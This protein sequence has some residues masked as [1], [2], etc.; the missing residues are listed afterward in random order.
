MNFFFEK[1]A[2]IDNVL[3]IMLIM[4]F[5]LLY[6]IEILIKQHHFNI[7]DKNPPHILS[8]QPFTEDH[9][10]SRN[11]SK[12]LYGCSLCTNLDFSNIETDVICSTLCLSLLRH[13]YYCISLFLLSFPVSLQEEEL[14]P[15]YHHPEYFTTYS[16]LVTTFA[17]I[18]EECFA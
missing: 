16:H 5:L 7:N 2:I 13:H 12:S 3:M 8:G 6:S 18:L 4:I 15:L 10:K 11:S 14:I 1:D 17:E 9:P